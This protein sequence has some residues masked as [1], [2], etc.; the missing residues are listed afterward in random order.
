MM[1]LNRVNKLQDL[2][3]NHNSPCEH[4]FFTMKLIVYRSPDMVV[5]IVR[6]EREKRA[7]EQYQLYCIE[8]SV[9]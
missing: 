3:S 8:L 5:G 2:L 4:L 1:S 9:E 6:L 7:V